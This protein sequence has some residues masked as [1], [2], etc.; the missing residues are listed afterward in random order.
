[1]T[2]CEQHVWKARTATPRYVVVECPACG[3]LRGAMP[4]YMNAEMA[5]AL[6]PE[7]ATGPGRQFGFP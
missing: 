5:T 6:T 1:M 2:P 4:A 3:E 7:R